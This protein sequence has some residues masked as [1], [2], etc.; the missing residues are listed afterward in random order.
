MLPSLDG[1]GDV[2]LHIAA[3][4]G[5]ASVIV[6]AR[7]RWWR[8]EMGRHLM[9]YMGVVA[10]V[11]DLGVIRFWVGTE[12]VWFYPLRGVVYAC[13]LLVMG[14]RLRLQILA[15]RAEREDLA[16]RTAAAA[17]LAA[18][19]PTPRPAPP[20]TEPAADEGDAP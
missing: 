16:D 18:N 11:L 12:P 2:L 5:T 13:G 17:R 10:V 15:Q 14:W 9:A 6:H 4:I 3:I 1:V 7:V 19:T 8:T 20:T